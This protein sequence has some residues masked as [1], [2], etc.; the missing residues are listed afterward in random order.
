MA[1][2]I[3][4][5]VCGACTSVYEPGEITDSDIPETTKFVLSDALLRSCEH[6]GAPR[7]FSNSGLAVGETAVDFALQDTQGN[8]ISLSDLLIEKPVA[9]VFGSFT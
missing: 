1:I 6:A 7:N 8:I 5:L 3:L 9:M 4:I 2:I